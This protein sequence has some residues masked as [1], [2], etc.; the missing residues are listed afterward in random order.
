[1]SDGVWQC[2][3]CWYFSP[4]TWLICSKCGANP[5]EC[6]RATCRA[7]AETLADHQA[8]AAK[9][10]AEQCAPDEVHCSCVPHLRARIK[11]LEAIIHD[12]IPDR[13]KPVE[14]D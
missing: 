7:Q 8:D 12:A 3:K 4:T 14:P 5:S 1:V 13:C 10:L 6:Q 9:V 11:A 2:K